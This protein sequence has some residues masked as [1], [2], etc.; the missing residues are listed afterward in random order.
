MDMYARVRTDR[1]P[2]K[3]IGIWLA[4][5]V[6]VLVLLLC[7]APIVWGSW[8]QLRF[9]TFVSELSDSTVYAYEHDCL[10]LETGEQTRPLDAE[11]GYALYRRLC[12][13]GPGRLGR[14]PEADPAAVVEY[15][16]GAVLRFWSVKLVNPGTEREYGLFLCYTSPT[17]EQFAYDTDQLTAESVI[18]RL[19]AAEKAE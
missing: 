18:Q 14:V 17:G 15:G 8:Y 12:D 5:A 4:A 2:R 19:R 16:N 3:D 6:C 10:S 9:R 11:E 13:A 1:R 7:I